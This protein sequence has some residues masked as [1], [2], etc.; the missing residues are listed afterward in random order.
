MQNNIPQSEHKAQSFTQRELWKQAR[1]LML[2]GYQLL[3]QLKLPP[4]DPLRDDFYRT[5]I[6]IP[7]LIAESYS[8]SLP[9][10]IVRKLHQA[11][12]NIFRLESLAY[13]SFDMELVNEEE[14]NQLLIQTEELKQLISE[15]TARFKKKRQ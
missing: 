5:C 13:L 10:D 9:P 2:N 3:S 15:R 6:D 12:H 1:N 7:S 11:R 8:K 14:L 4:H